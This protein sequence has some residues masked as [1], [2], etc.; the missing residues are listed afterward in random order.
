M[1]VLDTQKKNY[2]NILRNKKIQTQGFADEIARKYFATTHNL[3][4]EKTAFFHTVFYKIL[5]K[6]QR[7]YLIRCLQ[8]P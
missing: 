6:K 7:K 3:S 8:S 2:E 5:E 1:G 4:K